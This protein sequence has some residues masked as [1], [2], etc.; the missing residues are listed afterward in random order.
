MAKSVSELVKYKGKGS[1]D[2]KVSK[3]MSDK[4]TSTGKKETKNSALAAWVKGK[5]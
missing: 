1:G 5:K 3:N 2:D 4:D